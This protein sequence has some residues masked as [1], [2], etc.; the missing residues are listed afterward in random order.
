MFGIGLLS[1]WAKVNLVRDSAMPCI[2]GMEVVAAVIS[3]EE[4]GGMSGIVGRGILIDN[5]IAA[6]FP[7][8]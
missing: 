6:A 1:E 8:A 4:A 5:R 7:T 3:R 2:I